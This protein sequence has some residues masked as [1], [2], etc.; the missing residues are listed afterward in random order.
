MERERMSRRA[1]EVLQRYRAERTLAPA[2]R[3]RILSGIHAKIAATAGAAA[4]AGA[5]AAGA[6]TSGASNATVAA[7]GAAGS[8]ATAGAG[9]KLA[10][11]AGS[12]ALKTIVG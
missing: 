12:T 6:H 9:T 8:T 11:F 7:G 10:L 4:G 3:A 1:A 5:A 2:R